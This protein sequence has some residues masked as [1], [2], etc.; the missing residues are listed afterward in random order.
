MKYSEKHLKELIIEKQKELGVLR[1]ELRKHIESSKDKKI[2]RRNERFLKK[3]PE[4]TNDI[5]DFY[6]DS[7]EKMTIVSLVK[8]ARARAI[9]SMGIKTYEEWKEKLSK[10]EIDTESWINFRS[11]KAKIYKDLKEARRK[12]YRANKKKI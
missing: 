11:L 4:M 2:L 8:I 7:I 9:I 1:L 5:L 6:G 3:C 12:K 10:F